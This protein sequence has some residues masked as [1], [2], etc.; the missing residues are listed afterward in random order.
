MGDSYEFWEMNSG[1]QQSRGEANRNGSFMDENL[2]VFFFYIFLL[3]LP[4][5]VS[6]VWVYILLNIGLKVT[7]SGAW[8][9]VP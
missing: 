8:G 4:L 2:I 1:V 7:L 6:E 3:Y 9:V 5:E